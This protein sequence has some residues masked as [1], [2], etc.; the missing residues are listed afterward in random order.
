M[1]QGR[2]MVNTGMVN[3]AARYFLPA[4]FC[5]IFLVLGRILRF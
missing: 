5:E 1:P 2:I 4:R 3:G